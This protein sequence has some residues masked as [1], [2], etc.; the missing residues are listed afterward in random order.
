MFGAASA[1]PAN[2][3]ATAAAGASKASDD[4]LQLGNPFADMFDAPLGGG[5]GG[6]GVATG[7]HNSNNI[8][9]NNNGSVCFLI[10]FFL[11]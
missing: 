1:Q 4:L 3:G 6:A 7:A 10:F 11:I 8:W 2:A 5:A 9:M